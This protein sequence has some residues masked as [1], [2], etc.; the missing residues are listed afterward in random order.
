MLKKCSCRAAQYCN[1]KCQKKHRQAHKE[2]CR[3]LT[4]ERKL[5][6][7]QKEKTKSP[8]KEKEEGERKDNNDNNVKTAPKKEGDECP[9]CLE[10]VSVCSQFKRFACCGKAIHDHCGT[11]LMSM[12]VG[13]NCPMC[14][15]PTQ[16]S[17]EEM[18]K[19]LRPWVKKKKEQQ[20]IALFIFALFT[21]RSD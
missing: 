18:V 16:T 3:H 17:H 6:K 19:Y 11:D 21:H 7:K 15:A 8:E 9:I 14:R 5:E 4:A 1:T 13:R 10:E 12:E 2:I 20:R